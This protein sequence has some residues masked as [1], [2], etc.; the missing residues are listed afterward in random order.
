MQLITRRSHYESLMACLAQ[1]VG[2]GGVELTTSLSQMLSK[3]DLTKKQNHFP[4]DWLVQRQSKHL[5]IQTNFLHHLLERKSSITNSI[6]H[7]SQPELNF[8]I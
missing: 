2:F 7:C 3:N 8:Q 5:G 4:R 6:D 1:G